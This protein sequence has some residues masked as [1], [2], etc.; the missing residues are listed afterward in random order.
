M[1]GERGGGKEGERGVSHVE[2]GYKRFMYR[3]PILRTFHIA[4]DF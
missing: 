1:A 4:V 2:R 3:R